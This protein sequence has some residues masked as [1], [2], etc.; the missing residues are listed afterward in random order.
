MTLEHRQR[1]IFMKIIFQD[2][3]RY[4]KK[5]MQKKKLGEHINV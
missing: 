1:T 2:K 5:S 4:V 3:T